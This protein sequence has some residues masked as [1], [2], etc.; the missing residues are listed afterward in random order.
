[1]RART[2]Q[3]IG[4]V[5]FAALLWLAAPAGA[6]FPGQ[7]GKIFYSSNLVPDGSS[8]TTR[9]IYRINPD[10]S[11]ARRLTGD[12]YPFDNG[13]EDKPALSPDGSTIALVFEDERPGVPGE[14]QIY[15]VNRDGTNPRLLVAGGSDPAWSPD[16]TKIAY[17]SIS[18]T[19]GYQLGVMNAD[20]SGQHLITTETD[21]SQGN[22]APD[23]SADGTRLAYVRRKVHDD[24]APS[25]IATIRPDGSGRKIVAS[26]PGKNPYDPYWSPDS[27]R[28]VFTAQTPAEAEIWVMN[29]DGS[30][31]Q[32]LTDGHIDLHVT[33][34]PNGAKLV[35]SSDRDVGLQLFTMPAAG[36]AVTEV[37]RPPLDAPQT[38]RQWRPY[39]DPTH[40]G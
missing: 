34:S 25:Q 26:M 23:W 5:A 21:L 28:I 17:T 22:Y 10:G 39:W 29:R 19:T 35:F 20:G 33:W 36:G 7:N 1:M 16:G 18:D 9:A 3:L 24:A 37:T 11:G 6:T 4:A 14:Y 15:L 27:Q 32:Q 40:P 38:L 2:P 30:G 13:E 8:D 31:K 12:E